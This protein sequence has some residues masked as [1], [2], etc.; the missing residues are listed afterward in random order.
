[1]NIG[2]MPASLF[3][4]GEKVHLES[5]LFTGHVIV[6]AISWRG[7]DS[8]YLYRV[9]EPRTNAVFWVIERSLK[10]IFEPC[11]SGEL[12]DILKNIWHPKDC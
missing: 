6:Q 4:P 8:R 1:M 11:D 9:A 2:Y 10:K 5:R 7:N 3:R 12:R